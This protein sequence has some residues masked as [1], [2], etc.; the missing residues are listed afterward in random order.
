MGEDIRG[1]W[2]H[3]DCMF[4]SD[5]LRHISFVVLRGCTRVD[6]YRCSLVPRPIYTSLGLRLDAHSEGPSGISWLPEH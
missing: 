5:S 3:Y 6:M 4:V 1:R 2:F